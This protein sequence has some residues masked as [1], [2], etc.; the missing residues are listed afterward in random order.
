MHTLFTRSF[1]FRLVLCASLLLW[2]GN[3]SRVIASQSKPQVRPADQ[4]A[5]MP[6]SG[7]KIFRN[8]CAACHGANGTG[9]GPAAPALK[10]KLPDL[11]TI[12]RR[13]GATFP[14]THVQ[15]V[16]AGDDVVAAHGSREMPIWG[17]IFH[18][19]EYDQD[20]GYVR[21]KNVTDYLKSI[22]RK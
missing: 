9:D 21:L 17:P 20:L 3:H 18:K 13:N 7:E 12:S 19:I 16:I 4:D 15:N 5:L 14:T 6:V 22:Q 2:I 11:T 8:Y 10:I 1:G